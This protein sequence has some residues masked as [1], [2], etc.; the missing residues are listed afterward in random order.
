MRRWLVIVAFAAAVIGA[1]RL[2]TAWAD[3][4]MPNP[5]D[6]AGALVNN[7]SP[8][9][10][11]RFRNLTLQFRCLVCQNESLFDSPSDFAADMRREVKDMMVNK[12]MTDKQITA[13]LVARYGDF[14]LFNPPLQSN[15]VMLWFGPFLLVAIGATTVLVYVRC[16]RAAPPETD[17]TPSQQKQVRALLDDGAG[18]H[19]A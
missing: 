11:D 1:S 5:M 2:Q 12:H 16:R 7:M 6:S 4:P 10:A 18:E 19:K 17:L 14:I 13:F 9:M 3:E 8:A 15:T